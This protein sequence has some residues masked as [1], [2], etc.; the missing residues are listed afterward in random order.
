MSYADKAHNRRQRRIRG[1]D[2]QVFLLFRGERFIKNEA[3][4]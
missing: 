4:P 2:G 1:R 3:E